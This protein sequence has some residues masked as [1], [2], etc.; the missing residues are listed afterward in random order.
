MLELVTGLH[1]EVNDHMQVLLE[2]EEAAIQNLANSQKV[3]NRSITS[4][5][6]CSVVLFVVC[7]VGQGRVFCPFYMFSL[8]R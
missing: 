7:A 2:S 5:L 8:G 4:G 1:D 6:P 3:V